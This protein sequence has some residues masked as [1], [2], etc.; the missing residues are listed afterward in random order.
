[1]HFKECHSLSY[2]PIFR[3]EDWLRFVQTIRFLGSGQGCNSTMRTFAPE[4]L[5]MYRPG[6]APCDSWYTWITKTA[7]CKIEFRARQNGFI[8]IISC[9]F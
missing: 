4:I 2:P 6:T 7:F 1:M 3:P 8:E 5:I 9:L